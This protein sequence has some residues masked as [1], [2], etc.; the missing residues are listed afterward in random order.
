MG[1]GPCRDIYE[2]IIENPSTKIDFECLDIDKDSIAYAM[3]LLNGFNVT[4]YCHNAFRFKANKEYD[5]VWSAGLFDYLNDKQFI[6]LLRLLFNIVRPSG[7]LVVGNFSNANPSRDYMEFAEWFLYHRSESDLQKLAEKAGCNPKSITIE[8]EP[9]GVNLFLRVRKPRNTAGWKFNQIGDC[10]Q[11]PE[12][13]YN[14][15]I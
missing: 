6:F 11:K 9:E 10:P 2:F 8:K 7:E 3:R 15:N 5:L 13:G 12:G 14:C 1:S 4:F